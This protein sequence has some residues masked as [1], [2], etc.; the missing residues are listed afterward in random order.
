[1]TLG[2]MMEVNNEASLNLNYCF[3]LGDNFYKVGYLTKGGSILK[4]Y[5]NSN[6]KFNTIGNGKYKRRTICSVLRAFY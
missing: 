5:G 1:M 2:A 6:H 4:E 3:S